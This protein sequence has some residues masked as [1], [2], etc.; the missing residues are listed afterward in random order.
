MPW[1]EGNALIAYQ[2]FRYGQYVSTNAGCC[3][4]FLPN[5]VQDFNVAAVLE[6]LAQG[7]ADDIAA[8]GDL[9]PGRSVEI[10]D[11]PVPI[12]DKYAVVRALKDGRDPG[13]GLL[14]HILRLGQFPLTVLQ[15]ISHGV[16]RVGHP[17]DFCISADVH[18]SGKFAEPPL[19][20][21]IDQLPKR[22][23]DELPGAQRC[24]C[25][26]Q[27]GA[28]EDQEGVAQRFALDLGESLRLVEAEAD[29]KPAGV[30]LKGG[31][32]FDPLDAIDVDDID[33]PAFVHRQIFVT[34]HLCTDEPVVVGIA[35]E[36]G[37]VAVRDGERGSFRGSLLSDV[38]GEPLQAE[39]RND[40]AAHTP[41][42]VVERQRKQYDFSAGRQTYREFSDRECTGRE[43]AR[44]IGAL[45]NVNLLMIAAGVAKTQPLQVG[46]DKGNECGKPLLN[47]IE[48]SSASQAVPRLDRWE[49]R[50]R[51]QN[52]TNSL[53]DLLLVCRRELGQAER[54][55]LHFELARAPPIEF[56]VRL[57]R[58]R[59]QKRD[60]HQHEYP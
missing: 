8:L 13:G 38:V 23:M 12:D 51:D 19:V 11:A 27:H 22:T 21:G 54:M 3:S 29:D 28:Q 46:H 47:C 56:V 15:R 9:C 18:A 39:T 4:D 60:S 31:I 59:R 35:G 55:V 25:Q 5:L 58:D 10:A 41:I 30:V 26:H 40:D 52:L 57:E 16:E 36:I 53:D 48:V 33:R 14:G 32:A 20:R 44:E 7:H 17:H 1:L 2:I 42:V 24:Q 34:G 45:G 43:R 37:S 6:R 50:Q 49:F